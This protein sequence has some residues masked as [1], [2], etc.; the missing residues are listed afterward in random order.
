MTFGKQFENPGL[1]TPNS[2]MPSLTPHSHLVL[3]ADQPAT[4]LDVDLAARP[5]L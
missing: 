2:L 5:S 3:L 4:A 1:M